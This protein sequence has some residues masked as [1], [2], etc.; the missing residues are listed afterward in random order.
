M[1]QIGRAG[2]YHSAAINGR[3]HE[4]WHATS[5]V[6]CRFRPSWCRRPCSRA[7]SSGPSGS[8][9]R[10][11]CPRPAPRWM[12]SAG[13]RCD[14]I[15]VTGD[16]Y[17]DHPSFGM[18]LVGRLLEAQGFRVGILSQPDWRDVEAFRALGRPTV[19]WGVT[20][21]NM[22]SMVNRYT[23]DRRLRHDDAYSPGGAGGKRPDRAA[24]RLRA[25]LPRGVRRRAR[26]HRRHRG[27]PAPD[28]PLRLLVGQ[29]PALDPDRRARPT[30]SSTA[31]ASA[32]SSRSRT[33]WRRARRPTPSP[34]CAA[35]RSRARRRTR[36]RDGLDR[37]RFDDDR[38]AGPGRRR[39]SIPTRWHASE[40]TPAD[41]CAPASTEPAG[42]VAARQPAAARPTARARWCACPTSTRSRRIRS[43]TRTRRA[44]CMSS[45]TRAT[46]ARWSSGTATATSG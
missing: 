20:A 36:R 35:R 1:P 28:R 46:R 12:S 34:T 26:R 38:H 13:I 39:P 2:R 27:E 5:R 8:A 37:D 11:S 10:P 16:A 4:A 25:A 18:A 24:D 22:D 14:V 41:A 15:L 42:L 6:S 45:R 19:M 33:G 17:V 7:G 32:P 3:R 21:G 31:T 44:S 30:C 23:S 43:S 40:G 29:G 9:S